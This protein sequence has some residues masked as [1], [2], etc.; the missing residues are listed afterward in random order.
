MD[1][2]KEIEFLSS[3]FSL[4]NETV[5]YAVLRNYEGL[6][7][8]NNSRD[9][10]VII[11][12]NDYNKIK[13]RLLSLFEQKGWKI[14]NYL[15]SDRLVTFVC[16]YMDRENTHL[17]QWDFFFHTSVFGIH[18]MSAEELLE[19]RKYNGFLYHVSRECEF[20]DKYL[21]NRAVGGKYPEKYRAI[22][23]QVDNNEHVKCKLKK[24]Y[25]V[26]TIADCDKY[27]SRQLLLHACTSNF[28]QN[29]FAT[30]SNIFF[31]LYTF[32]TNYIRSN[33]GF[34]V[35]FTGPDGSGKT[36]V[37]DLIREQLAPVF[38]SATSYFHFRPTLIPNA[39]E[40]A[41]NA[42]VKKE[43]DREYDRPHRGGKTNVFSSLFRLL[44]Y[45]IDYII[46]Y[47]IRIKTKCRITRL[48]IFDRYYTDIICDSR[49]SRIFLNYKFLY[50]FGKL[51]I[52]S[53][54]YNI[55]LTANT[56]TILSRKQELG[57]DGIRSINMK[58]NYLSGKSGYRRVLNEG[59]PEEAVSEILSYIFERQHQKNRKRLK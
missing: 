17:I 22:R 36:T 9:I 57:A 53:L 50:W 8:R 5:P 35:G 14:I 25:G 40:A 19:N 23:E 37:I 31:F 33:T 28:K 52:P 13:I 55:L 26:S 10:D 42:G 18:L 29:P 43:V 11:K 51:F 7:D 38:G 54:D 12:Y 41:L 32:I 16:A 39:G 21:Y 48:V 15:N 49:R 30:L 2:C 58:I 56:E 27:N 59:T 45:S 46:G 47:F 44:Y 1:N 20:L 3:V 24:L 4:L 6:P 34:S